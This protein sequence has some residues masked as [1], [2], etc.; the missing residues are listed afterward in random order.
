[1]AQKP[2]LINV[3]KSVGMAKWIVKNDGYFSEKGKNAVVLGIEYWSP[4]V[5]SDSLPLRYLVIIIKINGMIF[6]AFSQSEL[7][8]ILRQNFFW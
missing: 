6:N 2:T 8:K 4:A 7:G 5:Q 3:Q 1:M